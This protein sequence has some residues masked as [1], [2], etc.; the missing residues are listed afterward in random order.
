MNEYN[1]NCEPVEYLGFFHRLIQNLSYIKEQSARTSSIVTSFAAEVADK[2]QSEIIEAADGAIRL[3][4]KMNTKIEKQAAE[5][6][7]LKAELNFRE[8]E[9]EGLRNGRKLFESNIKAE[10]AE[11]PEIVK[12]GECKFY[13]EHYKL[14]DYRELTKPPRDKKTFC[15]KGQRRESEVGK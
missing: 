5:I 6:E 10:L 12:C 15:S 9:I 8:Q 14:C 1:E 11:R 4:A 3:A 2:I 7:R 13:C